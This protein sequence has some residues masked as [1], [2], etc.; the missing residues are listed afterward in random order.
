M[1]VLTLITVSILTCLNLLGQTNF[2]GGIYS[3]TTWAK[4]KS[5]YIIT[6]NV[7]LF[8]SKTLTIEPGVEVRFNGNYYFE[9]RGKL[10]TAGTQDRPVIFT[11][12]MSNPKINDWSG[13]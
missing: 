13:I 12:N 7:V 1:K 3:N 10:I 8:P 11:S 6:G 9:V 5:P 4:D 2:Q